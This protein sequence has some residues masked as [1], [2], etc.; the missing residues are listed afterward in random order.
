VQSAEQTRGGKDEE[1]I[2]EAVA[3]IQMSTGCDWTEGWIWR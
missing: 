2:K 3:V 1:I